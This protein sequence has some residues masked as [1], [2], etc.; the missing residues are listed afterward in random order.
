MA[1]PQE[2]YLVA[3]KRLAEVEVDR[4][5]SHQRERRGLSRYDS[6]R[7]NSNRFGDWPLCYGDR[8]TAAEAR[9]LFALI[10]QEADGPFGATLRQSD[11]P[12]RAPTQSPSLRCAGEERNLT[13]MAEAG[14]A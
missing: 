11:T 7:M 13:G 2:R 8:A 10:R 14:T 3:L 5:A 4:E 6:Q 9:D 12:G 1:D